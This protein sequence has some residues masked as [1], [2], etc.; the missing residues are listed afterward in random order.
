MHVIDFDRHVNVVLSWK[1]LQ[2]P[3]ASVVVDVFFVML[4]FFPFAPIRSFFH[5][6]VW[7]RL[8]NS[9][10]ST[11]VSSLAHGCNPLTRF[12]ASSKSTPSS[13]VQSISRVNTIQTK[14]CHIFPQFVK[15]TCFLFPF[16]ISYLASQLSEMTDAMAMAAPLPQLFFQ[17]SKTPVPCASSL[18]MYPR[19]S[20]EQE[21]EHPTHTH[22]TQSL[23]F[24][25]YQII[26]LRVWV[27]NI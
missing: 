9:H 11:C 16:S 24:C 15:N 4:W 10:L 22:P 27:L 18:R 21:K 20:W 2:P 1:L 25:S 14:T 8:W 13:W 6:S 7:D 17:F 26:S 3:I 19:A 12:C 5:R 23:T